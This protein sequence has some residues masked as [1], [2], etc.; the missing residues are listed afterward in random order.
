MIL[1]DINMLLMILYMNR[2]AVDVTVDTLTLS[3]SVCLE[4]VL[5]L[6]YEAIKHLSHVERLQKLSEKYIKPL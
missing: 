2:Y 5:S 6:F 4:R 1:Y 3:G